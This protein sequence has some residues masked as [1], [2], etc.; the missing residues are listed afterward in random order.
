MPLAWNITQ[1]DP[2]VLV[3][4]ADGAFDW[5]HPDMEGQY[6]DRIFIDPFTDTQLY[7]HGL[8]VS[9]MIAAKADNG[10][11]LTGVAPDVKIVSAE[12]ENEGVSL[13]NGLIALANYP[14]NI[15]VIN[16][17]WAGGNSQY[18]QDAMA[19]VNSKD[20]LVVGAA[21]NN[22]IFPPRYPGA[23]SEAISVTTVGHRVAIGENHGLINPNTGVPIWAKSW[24]DVHRRH[25]D[26]S[27]HNNNEL[28]DVTAPG[29]IN[30]FLSTNYDDHPSGMR[31]GGTTS[32]A[33]PVVTGVAA[34]VF[35]ANPSLSALEVRDII[36]N[37]ADDIYDISYNQEFIGQLGTG[38]INAYRAVLTADCM[39]NPSTDIDLA[40]QNS[41]EDYLTEPDF[42]TEKLW[43]SD[44]IW[45][46]NQ[47][48]TDLID[49]HQNPEYDPVNPN[50]AYVRV[51]NNSCVT[52]S[53]NDIMKLYWAKANT[54][55]EWDFHWKG[56]F[57]IQNPPGSGNFVKMGDEIGSMIIPSLE[58]GQSTVLQFEWDVPNPD[59]YAGINDNPWHFCLLA[60]IESLDDPMTVPEGEFITA[61]VKN[62][63]NIAWKNMTVVDI[64][65]DVPSP[66]AA[67]VA[68]G[69]PFDAAHSFTLE[70]V[71]EENEPGSAL[72][73]EA[74]ITITLDNIL[75]NAW[76]NGGSASTN[77]QGTPQNNVIIVENNHALIENL[78]FAPN[79]IGTLSISFNFLIDELTDKEKY[80]Y[81]L[82]QRDAVTG[83]VIGGE[84]FEVRK[85]S[86]YSFSADAGGDE[87]IDINETIT[88]TAATIDEPAIYN[89]Y[90]PQGN[91]IH[92]GTDL[93][94]TPEMTQTYQLEVISTFDG[95]KDYDDVEVI[96]NPYRIETLVPNPTS[97]QVTISYLAEGAS[98][99]Y[100][101]IVDTNTGSSEN[102]ILD[103][104][105][106]SVIIDVSALTNGLYDI[107]L[108]CDGD[109]Q[110]AK[111]L[112]KQ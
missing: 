106:T 8:S 12:C 52:S 1:G 41:N 65:P 104:L 84:T 95:F 109:I 51:T 92:T 77:L 15:R 94:I 17:S 107:I 16:C 3:G 99:A 56:N 110:N 89:W 87:E 79:E 11:F 9:G 80:V 5:V 96:V 64:F 101:M 32:G 68:V 54:A 25:P 61:N 50:Y 46:R 71:K 103:T 33:T 40:M 47:L 73:D 88:L 7:D 39:A 76:T 23:Y 49:V 43:L 19:I 70:F 21:G 83:E 2:S 90:D 18:L 6:F 98:S 60:R 42:N 34:L 67:A 38:R 31:F 28:V 22:P 93:T 82:I 36:K 85:H 48:D 13:I 72:Y 27:H 111:T 44:D 58:I 78:Q 63:N 108:V 20:I 112:L 86:S 29:H 53:G 10:M 100:L 81:H 91:L 30:T 26:G 62:N 66:V 59:D 74:E 55:L 57:L 14:G 37:T 35:S 24:K 69:N 97:S 45:V 102:F 4:V 105:A 75:L